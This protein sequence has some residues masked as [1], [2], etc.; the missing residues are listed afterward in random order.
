MGTALK[1]VMA[2]S[3]WVTAPRAFGDT[4]TVLKNAMASSRP[5]VSS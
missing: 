4:G 2:S 1:N 5:L 3:V